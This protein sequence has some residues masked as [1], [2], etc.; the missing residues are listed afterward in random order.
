MVAGRRYEARLASTENSSGK[1]KTGVGCLYINK[2]EDID[3]KVLKGII[4]ASLN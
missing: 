4:D 3:L 2:L 1:H